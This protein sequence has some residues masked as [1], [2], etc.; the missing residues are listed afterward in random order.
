MAEFRGTMRL[1]VSYTIDIKEAVFQEVLTD[2][3]R[4]SFYQLHTP[5]DVAEHLAYN[6]LCNGASLDQ[7]DGFANRPWQDAFIVHNQ[8]EFLEDE[9]D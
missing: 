8:W 3:W 5:Q 9:E 7:L 1:Q 2:A 4:Q 6:F